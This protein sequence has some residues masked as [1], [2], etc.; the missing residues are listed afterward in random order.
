M[1]WLITIGVLAV[2]LLV[3]WGIRIEDDGSG[4]LIFVSF[5]PLVIVPTLVLGA[6]FHSMSL[7]NSS[8]IVGPLI[9]SAVLPGTYMFI[10]E[11]WEERREKKVAKEK[12]M[13][14][15]GVGYEGKNIGDFIDDLKR[16]QVTVLVDV[17]LNPISRKKGFRKTELSEALGEHGIRYVHLPALGNPKDNRAG[18]GAEY[19]SSEWEEACENYRKILDGEL[20]QQALAYL[21]KLAQAEYEAKVALMCFEKDSSACHRNVIL[22][23]LHRQKPAADCKE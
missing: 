22:G 13:N 4:C 10:Q 8:E 3:Y 21:R 15:Y 12:C 6:I 5:A 11:A 17:R 16:D 18:F 1:A 9:I 23:Y 7:D 19:K 2:W 14:V 20:A